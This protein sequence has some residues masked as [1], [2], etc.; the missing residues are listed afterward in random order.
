MDILV[1]NNPLAKEWFKGKFRVDF[2]ET[3]V[4]GVLINVRNLIHKGHHL[5]SHPLSGS[6]KPNET[7][8]KSVA[9]TELKEKVDFQ[10]VGIIE[11]CILSVQ[12]FPDRKI[13]EEYENDM[14]TV[15]LSLIRSA[16]DR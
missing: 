15:D 3:D 13:P 1:T 12:K 2:L 6:V 4:S 5:L 16:L 7:Y 14:Q 10:S 8:Y 9:V 11:D